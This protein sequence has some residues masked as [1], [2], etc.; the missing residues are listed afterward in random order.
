METS[1]SRETDGHPAVQLRRQRPRG[2]KQDKRRACRPR[3]AVDPRELRAASSAFQ[4]RRAGRSRTT[5]DMADVLVAL[6]MQ[7]LQ[8]QGKMLAGGGS[9][10]TPPASRSS[11]GSHHSLSSLSTAS[12]GMCVGV[13]GSRVASLEGGAP[14]PPPPYEFKHRKV[15]MDDSNTD[16][17]SIGSGSMT[18]F[19]PPPGF[20]SP[21]FSWGDDDPAERFPTPPA[22]V[23]HARPMQPRQSM[24]GQGPAAQLS[25]HEI[26]ELMHLAGPDVHA[27]RPTVLSSLRT[28]SGIA[29]TDVDDDEESNF[30]GVTT[31]QLEELRLLQ[32]QQR[33]LMVEQAQLDNLVDP[34]AVHDLPPPPGFDSVDG[35]M[36]CA[37]DEQL[38]GYLPAPPAFADDDDDDDEDDEIDEDDDDV[39]AGLMAGVVPS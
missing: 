7:R 36:G 22:E 5:V 8:R 24:K 9:P 33:I 6:E 34:C 17:S 14:P 4:A 35:G 2:V 13:S 28:L 10:G 3:S 23:C 11:F 32:V 12:S 20:G 16:V 39:L 15:S 18:W 1:R 19:A 38:P 21:A 25:D 37:A 30:D 29:P 31:R 27:D 26:K